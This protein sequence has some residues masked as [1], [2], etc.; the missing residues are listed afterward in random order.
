M[1]RWSKARLIVAGPSVL[2][3]MGDGVREPGT[4]VPGCIP[5]PLRGKEGETCGRWLRRGPETRADR[6]AVSQLRDVNLQ[7]AR[8]GWRHFDGE[9]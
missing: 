8:S 2:L 3:G 4:E 9:A 1:P 7:I 6:V 5:V